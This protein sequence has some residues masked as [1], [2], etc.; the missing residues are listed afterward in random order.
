MKKI[1]YLMMFAIA[2]MACEPIENRESAGGA[3]TA[4]QLDISATPMVVDGK[5]SNRIILENRSPVLSQ[6]DYGNGISIKAYDEV[7]VVVT[8]DLIVTFTGLNADGTKITKELPIRVDELSFEVP[9]A[10]GYLCGSGSKDWTWD[11]TQPDNGDG[12]AVWGNGNYLGDKSP[13]WWS[14]GLSGMDDTAEGEGD[15]AYMTFTLSGAK[16]TL[17]KTD[18]TQLEGSFSFD[19][20]DQTEGNDGTIWSIGKLYT[21]SVTV[22]AG[23]SPNEG[24]IRVYEYYILQLDDDKLVLAWPTNGDGGGYGEAFYWMFKAK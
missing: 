18:G 1:I 13:G 14:P 16:L 9:A 24:N 6:W 11:D 22:L 2:F 10:W 3:I 12:P 21:N 20:E 4:D 5:N 23:I 15:G 8:G 7:D 19:M 17:H